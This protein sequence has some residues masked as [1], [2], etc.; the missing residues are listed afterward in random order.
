MSSDDESSLDDLF[1]GRDRFMTSG[2]VAELLNV[3]TNTLYLWRQSGDIDLP[4]HRFIAPGQSRGMIRYRYSDV[5]KFITRAAGM[6][7]V[8]LEETAEESDQ[9]AEDILR[10]KK[11]ALRL[12]QLKNKK[13]K[14]KELSRPLDEIF[15]ES[16]PD[17]DVVSE[18]LPAGHTNTDDI[19][20]EILQSYLDSERK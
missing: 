20:K 14:D 18:S 8:F 3:N 7:R 9:R 16:I 10:S 1:S 6:G 2:E 13:V 4:F 5:A 11:S 12:E 15:D 17:S 19:I